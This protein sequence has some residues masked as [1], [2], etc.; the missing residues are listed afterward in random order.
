[1]ARESWVLER[2]KTLLLKWNQL[3]ML[4]EK[5]LQPKGIILL[6]R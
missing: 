1:M 6:Q 3:Q 4:V 5:T 2:K